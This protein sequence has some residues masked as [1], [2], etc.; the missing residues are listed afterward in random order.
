M[1]ANKPGRPGRQAHG[2]ADLKRLSKEAGKKATKEAAAKRA[3]AAA[4]A[5]PSHSAAK[6]EAPVLSGEDIQLF[7]R[8]MK[9]VTPIKDSHRLALALPPVA[10]RDLLRQ[11]REHAAGNAPVPLPQASDHYSPARMD[12]DDSFYLA[13]GYGPD[14]IKGLKRGKWSIGASLDLHGSTLEQARARLDR[15]LQTC[16]SHQIKCVRVVHGK[17]YGSKDGEPVLR[18]TTRRWLSQ[19]DAVMAYAECSEQD[20]G[21]GAVQVLLQ[22]PSGNHD[23]S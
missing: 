10:G 23:E 4:A 14:L 9:T 2:L 8:T 13:R 17:G 11:R 20:G 7:R 19:I 5:S 16:I 3:A 12:A 21:A 15:F 1:P 18:Q 6:A 22:L